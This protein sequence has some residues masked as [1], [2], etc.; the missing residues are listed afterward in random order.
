MKFY[1]N[2]KLPMLMIAVSFLIII[3]FSIIKTRV[4]TSE[5][6]YDADIVKT[7]YNVLLFGNEYNYGSLIAICFVVILGCVITL[8]YTTDKLIEKGKSIKDNFLNLKDKQTRAKLLVSFISIGI[9]VLCIKALVYYNELTDLRDANPY[10]PFN[11]WQAS[12]MGFMKVG[13]IALPILIVYKL[14]TLIKFKRNK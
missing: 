5:S 2:K 7:T 13:Q 3:F 14:I 9:I 8:F 11:K 6:T 10:L 4:V 12:F 1:E